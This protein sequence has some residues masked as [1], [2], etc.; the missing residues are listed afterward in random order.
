MSASQRRS[1]VR[2]VAFALLALV[3]GGC[4]SDPVGDPE[5]DDEADPIADAMPVRW[6]AFGDQGTGDDA[7]ARVAA[8]ML[9]V[10]QAAGCDFVVG[11]GDNIYEAGATSP[12]DP[13]F[14]LKFE[15]PYAAFAM[16][17]YMTLG[18]HDNGGVQ[19]IHAAGDLEVGYAARTDRAMDRW[20]MPNRWYEHTHGPV[21]FLA[22]DTNVVFD[23]RQPAPG[24]AGALTADVDGVRQLA[25]VKERLAEPGGATWTF[26][27]DHHPLVSNGV[28]G[29][30]SIESPQL[31]AWL[32]EAV[33]ESGRV[34]ALVS[35]HD[36][37]L[38]YLPA[39]EGC[40]AVEFVVSGA[41]AQVRDISGQPNPALYACGGTLGFTWFEA[42]A[43]VLTVRFH[44]ADGTLMAERVL[45]RDDASKSS[46]VEHVR[47]ASCTPT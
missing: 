40:G 2:V 26:L 31:G 34:D 27:H 19:D 6:L 22:L 9:A 45:D 47:P 12:Y 8:G 18:N 23:D 1:L 37:D 17:F 36:H 33:C 39:H 46:F 44:D 30:S 41:A 7:Q 24:T 29:D 42:K 20:V 15:Q 14:L 3:A 13:Q 21:R 16:P 35:G 10:C 11:L 25:W 38:Q 32:Q 28:H 4:L 43:E 5:E